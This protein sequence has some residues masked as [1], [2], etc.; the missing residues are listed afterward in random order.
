MTTPWWEAESAVENAR[1][2]A[3]RTYDL[4][5]TGLLEEYTGRRSA[6][7]EVVRQVADIAVGYATEADRRAEQ[8]VADAATAHAAIVERLEDQAT[9]QRDQI[10]RLTDLLEEK[11]KLR[12]A[13]EKAGEEVQVTIDRTLGGW[14]V[15]DLEE[16]AYRLRC[17]GAIDDTTVKLTDYTATA[18]VPAPD[19]VRLDRP[20][21]T[22]QPDPRPAPAT[23]ET[24]TTTATRLNVVGVV[25]LLGVLATLVTL[26]LR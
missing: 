25:A 21:P 15:A 13:R 17:G 1:A 5:L 7:A 11:R 18:L 26:L 3:A 14:T 20:T 22:R 6:S 10:A 12:E 9:A 4:R 2:E 23:P 8:A 19:L 16:I 24:T